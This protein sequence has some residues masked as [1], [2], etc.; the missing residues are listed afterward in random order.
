MVL[1]DRSELVISEAERKAKKS[2][3]QRRWARDNPVKHRAMVRRWEQENPERY[4]ETQRKSHI[5]RLERYRQEAL[6]ILGG[7]CALCQCKD[8]RCLQ[9]DHIVPLQ[10]QRRM[11]YMAL[12][13]S[14]VN[15]GVTENL[16]I[17]CANCHAIKTYQE[18]YERYR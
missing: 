11:G 10:G 6:S 2:E 15:K 13:R 4:K 5:K 9:I 14:I 1:E 12:Y 18:N 8:I 3:K 17:L 16:Q 7:Q